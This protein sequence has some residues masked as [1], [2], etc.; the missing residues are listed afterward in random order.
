MGS[1]PILGPLEL[2]PATPACLS[3]IIPHRHIL[4]AGPIYIC[5]AEPGD[6]VKIE[7]LDLYPR[8]NPKTGKTYGSQVSDEDCRALQVL[9]EKKRKQFHRVLHQCVLALPPPPL[10]GCR[11]CHHS[12]EITCCCIRC[13]IVQ[14]TVTRSRLSLNH[15]N[16]TG[17]HPLGLP[18]PHWPQ[19]RQPPRGR[20]HLRVSCDSC[21]YV[22]CVGACLLRFVNLPKSHSDCGA[23]VSK[24]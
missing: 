18:L 19:D 16:T 24:G 2:S 12:I 13:S 10:M 14:H 3:Q 7:I 15:T 4:S 5:G 20:D 23:M 11:G 8:P 6:T 21:S 22:A 17:R 1:F 9:R